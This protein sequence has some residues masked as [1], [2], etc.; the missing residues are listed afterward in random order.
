MAECSPVCS[1]EHGT[2]LYIGYVGYKLKH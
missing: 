2:V 1:L